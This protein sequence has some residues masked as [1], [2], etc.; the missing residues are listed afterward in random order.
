VS[1][2][3][4]EEEGE[5]GVEEEVERVMDGVKEEKEEKGEGEKAVTDV[6]VLPTSLSSSS[7]ASSSVSASS[8]ITITTTTTTITFDSSPPSLL[9]SHP[10]LNLWY[11]ADRRFFKPRLSVCAMLYAPLARVTPTHSV[12][13][14]LWPMLLE[15]D[16]NEE[17]YDASTAGLSFSISGMA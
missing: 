14:I 8:S 16:L 3:Q 5:G 6:D 17:T 11:Q 10:H 9:L 15:D 2:K 1:P 13:N 7:S 4:D 12:L